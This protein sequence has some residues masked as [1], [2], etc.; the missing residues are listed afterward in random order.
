MS[1][2]QR[3]GFGLQQFLDACMKYVPCKQ[4]RCRSPISVYLRPKMLNPFAIGHNWH[5]VFTPLPPFTTYVICSLTPGRRQLKT[6]ILATN[7]DRKSLET[8]FLIAICCLACDKWQ[9]K[10]RFLSIFDQSSSIVR[11]DFDCRLPG[12]SLIHVLQKYEHRSDILPRME[13]SY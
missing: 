11:S 7:I 2:F 9:S 13:E 8:E 12:V 6:L 4:Q 1:F 10:T 3:G 5:Y